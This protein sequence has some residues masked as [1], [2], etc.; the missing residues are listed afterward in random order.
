MDII[1][2][3]LHIRKRTTTKWLTLY[4]F[5][6]PFFLSFF[7]ELLHAPGLVKYTIDVAWVVSFLSLLIRRNF[8]FNKKITPFVVFISIWFVYVTINYAFHYQSVFYYLWG[9]RNNFR[10]YAAFL[11]FA[12]V[13]DEDDVESCFKFVDY[14][15]WINSIV[16]L[17]QFTFFGY[18]Q[19]NLGGIFGVEKG[20]NAYTSIL[21]GVVITRSILLYMEKKEKGWLCYV[22]CAVA[23]LIAAMAEIKFFF[24]LFVLIF[25]VSSLLTKF[26]WRKV[27]MY[28]IAALFIFVAGRVLT[29]IF[30]AEEQ[31]TFDRLWSLI[32]ATNYATTEDLGRFTAIPIVS[33]RF[34]TTLPE[35][36]VGMGLG[37]CDTSA[38]AICNT[39]F[40][41]NYEYL[42][43][44]W[45][46]S[47]FLFLETGYVGLILNLSFYVLSFVHS[48]VK[49]KKGEGN[50]LF[51]QM[52]I[53]FALI[54]IVL[55]FYNS[56]LRKEVGYLAYFVLALPMIESK[57][58]SKK[59]ITEYE[60]TEF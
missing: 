8:S 5:L 30:G 20:C 18:R 48:I 4:I 24:I 9:I 56:A 33:E 32:T 38:F 49:L 58:P 1:K 29:G 13:L 23:L 46:S 59:H 45:F 2:G 36:L 15:F 50:K 47:A 44:N 43:Y 14:L 26:S 57:I 17:I 51:C 40:Y 37:N 11:A 34:L 19:D 10:V 28:I 39:P 12:L 6:F 55:T 60:T 54:C 42:H 7:L 16:T 3:H 35:K 25:I 22:K 52:A 41:Q 53:V 27:V 31:L 21:L